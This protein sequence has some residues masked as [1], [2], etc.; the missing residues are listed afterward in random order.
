[1]TDRATWPVHQPLADEAPIPGVHHYSGCSPDRPRVRP[2]GRCEECD[3]EACP[4]CGL[5]DCDAHASAA[6]R[7]SYLTGRNSDALDKELWT[8]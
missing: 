2:D 8:I 1:M 6:F 7:E 3:R 4:V 5:E